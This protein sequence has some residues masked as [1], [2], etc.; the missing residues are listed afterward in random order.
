LNRRPEHAA[1]GVIAFAC[2]LAVSCGGGEQIAATGDEV[3]AVSWRE[4]MRTS[5]FNVVAD[6]P[7]AAAN[8]W[9]TVAFR[10]PDG[11]FLLVA[12][13]ENDGEAERA[14]RELRAALE[15][16]AADSPS[17][18]E[19]AQ[20]LLRLVER[21]G[22]LVPAWTSTPSSDDQDAVVRCLPG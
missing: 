19:E 8:N 11:A 15:A 16:E 10:S 14:E 22:R 13:A 20:R 9:P 17:Y 6:Y 3:A 21:R 1:V 2:T 18:R 12:V 7:A 4:C 5:G